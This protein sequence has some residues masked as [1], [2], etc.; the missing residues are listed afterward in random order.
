MPNSKS[1]MALVCLT[2]SLCAC[3][4]TSSMPNNYVNLVTTSDL[5]TYTPTEEYRI[6]AGDLLEVKVFQAPELSG[7]TRVDNNGNVSLPLIGDIYVKGLTKNQLEQKI[8]NLLSKNL[9]QNP[10]VTIFVKEFTSQR[11]TIEGSVAKPGIYP[12]QGQMTILQ[13]L[14]LAGGPADLANQ[15]QILLFRRV[16]NTVKVYQVNLSAI[17]KAQIPDPFLQNDDRIV[18]ARSETRFLVR[19]AGTVLSPLGSLSYIVNN[20]K[21]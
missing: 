21:N 20:L 3:T 17:R 6:G 19:E 10:Q 2:S 1:L 5:Y 8:Q 13:A 18:V 9:L 7:E 11:V 12:I 14:A 4:T 15:K 16:N